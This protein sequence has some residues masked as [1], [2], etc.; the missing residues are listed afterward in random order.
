M[1]APERSAVDHEARVL[2]RYLLGV[3][4]RGEIVERYAA[5]MGILGT[6]P[7]GDAV[8]G[9]SLRHP[10]AL[11]PL[12]AACGWRRPASALRKRLLIMSAILETHTAY[13]EMYVPRALPAWRLVALLAW[14]GVAAVCKLALGLLLLAAVGVV[15]ARR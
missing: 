9:Y 1:P 6:V 12:D 15:G 10:W 8:L 13:A 3:E 5:A 11:P 2:A 4:P 7:D 14:N